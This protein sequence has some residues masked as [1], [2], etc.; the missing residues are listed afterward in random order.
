MVQFDKFTL[1][2]GLRVIVHHDNTT[3]LV[4]FNILYDVGSRDE[5]PDRTGFAHLFEHLMFGGSANIP[6]F[7]KPLQVVGGENNAFTNCDIT[8]YYITLPKENL[9]TA[10]WLDSDRMLKLAFSKKSLD[11]QRQVVSEEFKQRYLNQPYGDVWLYLRPLAYKKHP[12]KWSTIGKDLSH[13]Q[14]ASMAEVKDFFYKWYAPNN[15]ILTV[16]GNVTVA[17]VKK[18]AM[19][20]FGPVEKRNVPV[21]KLPM[22]PVQKNIRKLS[23]ERDVPF[24]AIYKTYHMC[25]R[26]DK[27]YHATDLLSDLLSGG[28]SSRLFQRLVK[29][30]KMFSE[31]EGYITGSNDPGLFVF[32]GKLMKGVSMAA[33]D[34]AITG[35][36]EKIK[37]D[38]I[39]N[40]ELEKVKN[41][42]ETNLVLSEM[43]VLNKAMNLAYFESIGSA[44]DANIEAEK[45]R[46]VTTEG[47]SEVANEIFMPRNCSTLYYHAKK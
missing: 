43:N 44:S 33:A 41:K 45:Y 35:E 18:L 38:R 17:E 28:K 36:I 29:Q 34:D 20:Y 40:S 21:R 1:E 5:D 4:A 37:N 30:K 3:P 32:S 16:A 31:L 15:A 11:V 14:E 6:Q 25:S 22:E 27:N 7:D 13:I 42:I 9:E 23:L 12:Y 26:K 2:N 24:D 39:K 8:N 46:N 10:F 47:I 19:K